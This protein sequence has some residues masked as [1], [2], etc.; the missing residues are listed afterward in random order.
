MPTPPP[1]PVSA[2][3]SRRAFLA[4]GLGVAALALTACVPE[5]TPGPTASP[6]G[7]TA[8]AAK[9]FRLGTA[10]N[11]ATLDPA[12]SGD[13]E[14]FRITRQIY[15][16]L[17]GVDGET[18]APIP[19][20]ATDWISSPD[21]LQHTFILRRGVKFHDGTE[22]NAEAVVIN[23]QRWAALPKDAK[24]DSDQ[25]FNQVFRYSDSIPKLPDSIPAPKPVKGPDGQDV[26]DPQAEAAHQS[27]VQRLEALRAQ[28]KSNPFTGA[29]TGGSASYFGSIKTAGTHT[30][31]LTL[32][33]PITGLIE[34]LTLP[35]LVI[36]SPKALAGEATE[37]GHSS[38][39]SS[40]PVG[41]GPYAFASWKDQ[42]VEVTRFEGY[43]DAA[44]AAANTEAPTRVAFRET[45]TPAKRL[46]DLRRG[47]IDG[48][49]MVTVSGLRELVREGKLIVQRDPFSVSY[50]GMNQQNK[51][52]AKPGFRQAVA[53]AID[54]QRL[55]DAFY[56][57]G[58]KEA[59]SFLPASLGVKPSDTYFAP[60]LQ[61]SKD[62]LA[63]AGYDGS[64]IP[65]LYPLNISRAYLPLPEL[66]Y[67]EISR[68]LATA[69]IVVEPI[70]VDWT[71]GYVG[72]VRSGTTPGLHLLGFNGGYRD[73]DDFLGGIFSETTKQFGYSSPVLQAQ[74]LLA[75]SIPGGEE[76]VNAYQ[77]ISRTL[78]SELPALP[79]VF[80][81][82]ALAFNDT[83]KNYPSSPVLDEVFSDV[84]LNSK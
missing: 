84:K 55:I 19:L 73:P 45:S 48:F 65:F 60:D 80:P 10:A 37:P 79:L 31:V 72:R 56:I 50:L 58:T 29:S 67:A 24:A 18:G 4:G 62:L 32:R 40:H 76:R 39:V 12:V 2:A 66:I 69:G 81:I 83:V 59:R 75:R 36:A 41:T 21:R 53:H 26:V 61:R 42:T 64:P 14:A 74:I 43:W 23:F 3:A 49:D 30:V 25:G 8:P 52:L 54:R 78:A 6:T 46:G 13:N 7:T 9:T 44:A 63:E 35:G 5:R 17:I 20:L 16:G 28:L 1:V 33:R 77:D 57:S 68:Q 34:A 11:P 70:P 82:S 27:E 22:F 15:E 47:D 51:W 71:E 38:S